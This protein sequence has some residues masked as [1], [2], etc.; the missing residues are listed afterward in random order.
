MAHTLLWLGEA[1]RI[2]VMVFDGFKG[3]AYSSSVD[4]ETELNVFTCNRS[5]RWRIDWSC[6]AEGTARHRV[7]A[8]TVRQAE[9]RYWRHAAGLCAL[10]YNACQIM[11]RDFLA[12]CGLL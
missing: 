12:W 3:V 1:H 5:G 11:S 8:A 4:W 7:G 10:T 2:I 9:R 6:G